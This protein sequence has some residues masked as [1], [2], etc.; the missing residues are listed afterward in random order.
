MA[1]ASASTTLLLTDL[2]LQLPESTWDTAGL[3]AI[4]I[5]EV[6][7]TVNATVMTITG[8]ETENA[9]AIV[10]H[11]AMT[12]TVATETRVGTG[13]IEGAP[14]AILPTAGREE[15]TP[16]ARPGEAPDVLVNVTVTMINPKILVVFCHRLPVPPGYKSLSFS[17]Y[18]V[19]R[20]LYRTV[21]R[22]QTQAVP[23]ISLKTCLFAKSYG[24]KQCASSV[25]AN[26]DTYRRDDFSKVSPLQR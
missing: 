16:A 1:V 17:S 10:L 20:P 4:P 9:T 24:M 5:V 15:A 6:T 2:M 13:V 26:Q 21:S 19:S 23:S 18:Q 12:G 11:V 25:F 7:G 14:V 3:D 8:I 22:L